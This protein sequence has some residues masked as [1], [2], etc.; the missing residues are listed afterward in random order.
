[1]DDIHVVKETAL[2]FEKKPLALILPY[3]GSIFLQTRTK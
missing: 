3:F 1:M 2:T